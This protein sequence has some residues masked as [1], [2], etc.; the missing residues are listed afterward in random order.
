MSP[1]FSMLCRSVLASALLGAPALASEPWVDLGSPLAG[2]LG[3]PVLTGSGSL[4]PGNTISVELGNARPNAAAGL[5]LGLAPVSLPFKGGTLQVN[6]IIPPV[7]INTSGAGEIPLAF[8]WPDLPP[9]TEIS[10]Q[11]VIDDP[12]A[13]FGFAL[14]N[15]LL[16]TN[17]VVQPTATGT[18]VGTI[19]EGMTVDVLG[20]DFVLAPIDYCAQVV[21]ANG[22]PVAFLKGI[23]ANGTSLTLSVED[24][25]PGATTGTLM[26]VPGHGHE[27]AIA[28]TTPKLVLNGQPWAWDGDL[29]K[30]VNVPG[31]MTLIPPPPA[32]TCTKSYAEL[33]AF[34]DTVS[35]TFED[36][37]GL[38][39]KET[40]FTFDLHFN[41]CP[42]A[43]H[44]DANLPLMNPAPMTSNV[45]TAQIMKFVKDLF[46]EVYGPDFED[47]FQFSSQTDGVDW[48]LLVTIIDGGT[49]CGVGGYFRVCSESDCDKEV[50]TVL[51]NGVTFDLP[52]EPGTD[53]TVD[54]D[55][56]FVGGLNCVVS[57]T[58]SIPD[59]AP[60]DAVCA[61]LY[62]DALE[63]EF[64][65]CGAAVSGVYNAGAQ[66]ITLLPPIFPSTPWT[67][68]TAVQITICP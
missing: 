24:I 11:Y 32:T 31:P 15:G 52:C 17:D 39:L 3:D 64:A 44:F 49:F 37:Q 59:P 13:V 10:F 40:E 14:S 26:V 47:T 28:P 4:F 29:G 50:G 57:T 65:L 38:C 36:Y 6:P 2:T 66:E 23:A 60:S 18:S 20:T 12:A 9:E 35:F 53:V 61:Q 25:V 7:I 58:V 19:A 8:A 5:F 67:S 34:Q 55:G 33:N 1:R 30:V 43:V 51:P 68:S 48:T 27:P 46:E 16:A 42:G 21:D 54:I 45:C 22:D 41:K 62:I 63:A 56:T